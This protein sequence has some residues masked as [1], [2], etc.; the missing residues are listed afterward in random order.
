MGI[1]GLLGALNSIVVDSH[2]KEFEGK[3]VGID[4]YCWLH[5]A[6]YSCPI[7]IVQNL[8]TDKYVRYCVK[9]IRLL[10]QYNV[11]PLIVFDGGPLPMKEQTALERRVMRETHKEKGLELL[12]QG[13]INGAKES[14][15]KAIEI[16]KTM[17]YTLIK[18]FR[19]LNIDFIVAPYEADAQL[20]FLSLNNYIACIITE[21]SDLLAYGCAAVSALSLL[22][23]SL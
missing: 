1:S 15:Q 8:P 7:E 4:I 19:E 12:K 22:I 3:T 14:F 11:K 20:A 2:I 17:V 16:T 21:D 9:R 18:V 23:C 10:Q 13:D 5:K 6:A